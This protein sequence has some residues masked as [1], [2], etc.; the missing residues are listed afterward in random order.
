[1]NDAL[2]PSVSINKDDF[3]NSTRI[4]QPPVSA[5]G[6]TEDWHTLGFEWNENTPSVVYITV[7]TQGINNV[8]GVNFNVNGNIIKSAKNASVNTNYG[9]FST[10]RFY[11]PIRDFKLIAQAK[12]VKM[13]VIHI[14]N[15]TVSSFGESA[16]MRTINTKFSP[17]LEAVN[18]HL[19]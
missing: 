18:N 17:F 11:I 12:L 6:I 15:Y 2:T 10:R 16:G 9:D 13:K 1:M 3:D 19:K 8:S 5:S 4:L 14:D 7:G